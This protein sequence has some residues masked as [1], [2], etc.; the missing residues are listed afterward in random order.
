M[1]TVPNDVSTPSDRPDYFFKRDNTIL[2]VPVNDK[3]NRYSILFRYAV[4]TKC[5]VLYIINE[6]YVASFGIDFRWP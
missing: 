4:V 5:F 2:P 1:Y 6:L 3:Y